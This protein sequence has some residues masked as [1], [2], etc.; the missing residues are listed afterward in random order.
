MAALFRAGLP[1]WVAA[2]LSSALFGLAHA[3]QGRAGIVSTG[4][5]GVVLAL[6]RLGFG[7]LVPVMMWHAGLDLAAGIAAPKYLLSEQVTESAGER[8]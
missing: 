1:V 6:G 8:K 4:V 2:I 5:F 7:S 3:Y